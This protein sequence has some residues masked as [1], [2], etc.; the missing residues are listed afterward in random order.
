MLHG[1]LHSC[2]N[3]HHLTTRRSEEKCGEKLRSRGAKNFFLQVTESE[4][5]A[6]KNHRAKWSTDYTTHT[7]R[8]VKCITDSIMDIDAK[9]IQNHGLSQKTNGHGD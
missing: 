3:K 4:L 5:Y 6:P 8:F 7:V 2:Y 1:L 9:D